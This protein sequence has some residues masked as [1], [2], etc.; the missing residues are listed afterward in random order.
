M[1]VSHIRGTDLVDWGCVFGGGLASLE[2]LDRAAAGSLD[3]VGAAD[4]ILAGVVDFYHDLLDRL[5][6]Q[7]L[8]HF[9]FRRVVVGVHPAAGNFQ[10][11]FCRRDP[12]HA[13]GG[14]LDPVLD[15]TAGGSGVQARRPHRTRVPLPMRVLGCSTIF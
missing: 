10:G 1:L 8:L 3:F 11:N 13:E 15:R 9:L 4:S 5:P 2:G 7:G 6:L 12:C 14:R